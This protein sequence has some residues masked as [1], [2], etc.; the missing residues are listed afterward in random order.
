[1]VSH[2]AF[3]AIRFARRAIWW[4]AI[5]IVVVLL[6]NLIVFRWLSIVEF[7][8]L[9]WNTYHSYRDDIMFP[10]VFIG[11]ATVAWVALRQARLRLEEQTNADLQ[12]RLTESFSRAIEQIGSDKLEVRLGSI[13]TLERISRESQDFYWT[14]METLTGFLRDRYRW[15]EEDERQAQYYAGPRRPPTDLAAILTIIRRRS[16]QNRER[17]KAQGWYFDLQGADLRDSEL[18]SV[19]L[20]GARLDGV[21]LSGSVLWNA[22]LEGAILTG[23]HLEAAN[24]GDA[25]L[26][27]ANLAG[28][29]LEGAYLS[30]TKLIGANFRGA[31]LEGAYLSGAGFEGADLTNADLRGAYLDGAVLTEEQLVVSEGDARTRLPAGL[32]PPSVWLR[33]PHTEP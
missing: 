15:I 18:T 31:H 11:A 29:H 12:R 5:G 9:V 10:A 4:C 7:A 27:G 25:N 2:F 32:T 21:H 13:Y 17:E 22:N 33:E 8:S 1:M 3:R 24:L 19:N 16:D 6:V 14:T 23:S 30:G 28:A 20:E 26:T